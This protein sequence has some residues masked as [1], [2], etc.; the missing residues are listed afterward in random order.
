MLTGSRSRVMAGLSPLQAFTKL[1]G[2]RVHIHMARVIKITHFDPDPA[3]DSG[4]KPEY[5]STFTV[6][7]GTGTASIGVTEYLLNR[8][9][10]QPLR[11]VGP[12]RWLDGA[13]TH[14]G[15]CAARAEG[16]ARGGTGRL[17]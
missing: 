16:L 4:P 7:T 2:G 1:D 13:R 15:G 11:S 17:P 10:A 6:A 9:S 5:G 3:T 12:D 8:G 14:G